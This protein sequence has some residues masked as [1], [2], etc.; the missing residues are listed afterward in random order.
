[1]E[2]EHKNSMEETVLERYC[3]A[4]YH[5]EPITFNEIFAK[6]GFDTQQSEACQNA[7]IE[8]GLIYKSENGEWQLTE[9]GELCGESYR[10]HWES[11]CRFLEL[12]GLNEAEADIEAQHIQNAVHPKTIEK[13]SNFVNYGDIYERVIRNS[14]LKG[15]YKSG[16]YSFLMGIYKIDSCYPRQLADENEWYHQ[17]IKMVVDESGSFIVMRRINA[18]SDWQLCY[19]TYKDGWKKAERGA[20][21]DWIPVE[22][23]EIAYAPGDLIRE[24][25]AIIAFS[26]NGREP[27]ESHCKELNIHIW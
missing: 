14:D 7:L 3:Q 4:L 20:D 24:G 5:G 27:E 8:R 25:I 21:R 23:F 22:A 19:K 11:L 12:I 2:L 16:T 9:Y 1:M 10:Y 13:I 26:N 15:W 6:Y 18:Q 17:G